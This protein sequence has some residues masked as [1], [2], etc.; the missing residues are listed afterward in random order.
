MNTTLIN[1]LPP[2]VAPSQ[3][4]V[5]VV[6]R[7]YAPLTPVLKRMNLSAKVLTIAVMLFIP[8]LVLLADTLQRVQAELSFTREEQRGIVLA[9]D[10]LDLCKAMQEFR[11]LGGLVLAGHTP[12]EGPLDEARGAL[13]KA[14]AKAEQSIADNPAYELGDTWMPLKKEADRLLNKAAHAGR[15]Q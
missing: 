7:L 6:G 3:S 15:L 14:L 10:V 11:I 9:S 5:S 1:P 12:A 13:K 2:D 8:L 4:S